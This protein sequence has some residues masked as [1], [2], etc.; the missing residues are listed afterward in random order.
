MTGT[1]GHKN[2]AFQAW[3]EPMQCKFI[4]FCVLFAFDLVL[5]FHKGCLRV[6]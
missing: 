4:C 2:V 5:T 3:K 6:A 1:V